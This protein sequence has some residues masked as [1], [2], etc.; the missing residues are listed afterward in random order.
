MNIQISKLK[1]WLK[2][3]LLCPKGCQ[4]FFQVIINHALIT[5]FTEI[6]LREWITEDKDVTFFALRKRKY[7]KKILKQYFNKQVNSCS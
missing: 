7:L 3:F 2:S 4:I 6:D 5:N 1:L